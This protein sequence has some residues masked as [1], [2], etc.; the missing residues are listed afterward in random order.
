MP[1]GKV[2]YPWAFY[3]AVAANL[4]LFFSF[5]SL[6]S[7]L[8]LH[9]VSL[10][11][12]AADN[13]L[14]TWVFALAAL[15]ARPLAGLLADRWDR[16]AILLCGALLFG[17]GPLLYAAS[18]SVPLLL[19]ARVVHG[20]GMGFFTTAYQALV[21]GLLSP[22]RYGEGLGLANTASVVTMAAAPL[23]GE[24]VAM[25][26]GFEALFLVIGAI[27]GGGVLATLALPHQA[28]DDRDA[29]SPLL[30]GWGNLQGVWRRPEVR[31]GSLAMA[32]L[33]VPFGAFI[34][35]LPLLASARGVDGV[36]WVFAAYALT[37][38]LAQ[39]VAGRVA[40]RR[41]GG[42]T[43]L[44]G[45]VLTGLA[46]GGLAAGDSRW[47]LMSLAALFGVGHGTA[48]AGLDAWVQRGT[49]PAWRGSAAA[50]QYTAYDLFIGLGS[51]GL[52]VLAR[53]TGYGVMYTIAGGVTLLGLAA[54]LTMGG[55]GSLLFRSGQ[56]RQ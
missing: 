38:S 40:D 7:V 10:G 29:A 56:V 22:D 35:F 26:R 21:A 53:A 51:W 20:V 49:V 28:S 43:A 50:V 48:R 5:Q 13:G 27:G 19:G 16:K 55:W 2:V 6:F 15:L 52:G 37:A 23:F 14:A 44:V 47:E 41:G 54:G 11:G 3:V 1:K 39:S 4:V 30:P 46:A 24:R 18:S 45:L 33:G 42:R 36:G 12:S 25:E 34:S 32:L 9:I 31:V 17:G 8:P